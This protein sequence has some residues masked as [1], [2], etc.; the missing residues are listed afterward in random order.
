MTE[1]K[2]EKE[3]TP[4]EQRL[5]DSIQSL[6]EQ[7]QDMDSCSFGYEE[8]VLISGNEA[9]AILSQLSELR[10][11]RDKLKEQLS[12]TAPERTKLI[13]SLREDNERLRKSEQEFANQL[14]STIKIN[15]GHVAILETRDARIAQ[16]E[17]ALINL[18]SRVKGTIPHQIINQA[19]SPDAV[20]KENND[21]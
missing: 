8:G 4:E 21:H 1:H 14:R 6:K 15:N 9:I 12:I 17:S 19:L 16:L 18:R 3:Q 10:E 7:N 5:A 20:N 11:E 2:T 13:E